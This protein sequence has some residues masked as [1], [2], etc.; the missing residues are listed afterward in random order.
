M[1]PSRS[2]RKAISYS[3]F[4]SFS[5]NIETNGSNNSVPALFL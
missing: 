1:M 4:P 5:S 2:T 3:R